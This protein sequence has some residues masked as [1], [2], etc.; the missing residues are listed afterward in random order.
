MTRWENRR[1]LAGAALGLA[2]LLLLLVASA[3]TGHRTALASTRAAT[4]PVLSNTPRDNLWIT[5][6]AVQ[7]MEPVGDLLY[8]SGFSH[9]GPYTGLAAPLDAASGAPLPAFPR[10]DGN[11]DAGVQAVAPDGSGGW[12]LGGN[13]TQMGGVERRG[14]AHIL[15]DTGTTAVLRYSLDPQWNP[16]ANDKVYALAVSGGTVYVGGRFTAVGGQE[17]QRIAALDATTGQATAWNPAADGDVYTLAVSGNTLYVGGGFQQI[18]GQPRPYAAA[19]DRT[20]G[21]ATDWNALSDG[22][23]YALAVNGTT[24]YAGGY[25]DNIG[26]S[27]H[28]NI[29]A[30]NPT[31]GQAAN[32]HPSIDDAVSALAVNG[33]TVY[34]GGY[35]DY[36]NHSACKNLVFLDATTGTAKA[37][38]GTDSYG[39]DALALSGNALYVGG[40]FSHVGGQERENLAALDATTGAVTAWNPAPDSFVRALAAS[41]GVVYA[42]GYFRSIGMLPRAMAAIQMSSGQPTD[43]DP[44]LE[45]AGGVGPFVISGTMAYVGGYFFHIGGQDR[46]HL[47]ELDLTTG[48]ATGWNP[49][50]AGWTDGEIRA[51]ARSGNTI[52]VGGDF[53]RLG[54][55]DHHHLAAVDATTGQVLAWA[56][57]ADKSVFTLAVS[58][59]TVYA[60]GEFWDVDGQRRKCLAALDAA[61][62]QVLPWNPTALDCSQVSTLVV[63]GTTLY[64]GGYFATMGGQE[65]NNLA[66][67]NLSTGQVTAWN[68]NASG[69]VWALA[70]STGTVYASGH[71]GEIGG[72]PR[73]RLAAMDTVTGQVKA[74]NPS[75]QYYPAVALTVVG[76]SLYVGGKFQFVG[77]Q[78]R[79]SLVAFDPQVEPYSADVAIAKTDERDLVLPGA[80]HT[81]TITVSNA[82]PDPAGVAVTDLFPA[83][84]TKVTWYCRAA[85]FSRCTLDGAVGDVNTTLTVGPGDSVTLVAR[86]TVSRTASVTM[87]NT[88][89][90]SPPP[91]VTDPD[92]T[93]NSATDVTAIGGAHQIYL[94]L[95]LRN[96]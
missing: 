25:F 27:A 44:H 4:A 63:S 1:N 17:R 6:Y 84:F 50:A 92:L 55:E 38:P 24:V 61:S 68:P 9:V 87:V 54:G 10:A 66:A 91:G 83:A 57:Q 90:V 48:L 65:R 96:D 88:A 81:Y 15:P 49:S 20:T 85:S 79:H 37:C 13:F 53:Y 86:G 35:F 52:Y 59:N 94:P 26:W 2:L 95:V 56:P 46:T 22:P 77:A 62:G 16:D 23:V 60:G 82:G 41:G 40:Q 67:I 33:T 5:D 18:G 34:A 75:L 70:A 76:D 73:N 71:F 12:Y 7:H 42:G 11:L 21:R 19:L 51:M 14:L 31:T 30:L 89:V 32:W 47:A 45:G 69:A 36:V 39:P 43:W 64:V 29:A 78:G 93:N 74:W 8:I 28:E 3:P 80:S 58:G 72:Q